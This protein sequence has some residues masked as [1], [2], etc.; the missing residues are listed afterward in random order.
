MVPMTPDAP[1][2]RRRATCAAC[3]R[4]QSACICRWAT[5]VAQP[6]E[7]LI[8]QHPLES[9][10]PKGS[11]R[12]LH[13]SLPGSR[14][15]AGEVFDVPA[16]LAALDAAAGPRHTLLL[17][18]ETAQDA[19]CGLA[20]PPALAPA[21]LREPARLRLVVLD[22]TWRKSRKMLHLNPPLQHLPRLALR[23]VPAS[24]YRVRKAP[25]PDQL[26]TLEATCAAL[27][28]LDGGPARFAPLLGAFDGFVAAQ[29][30]RRGP[31]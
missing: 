31:P 25:G 2:P 30:A 6:V 16:L 26:S 12:L 18:P 5:P 15:L 10:N 1:A 19:A 13:L 7:V 24:R 14:L 27:A 9:N 20:A 4:P 22:G 23:D 28:R 17:Y 29:I 8:L 11:A 3:L 21:L